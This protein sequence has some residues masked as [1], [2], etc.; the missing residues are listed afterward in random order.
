[1]SRDAALALNKVDT[2]LTNCIISLPSNA[3]RKIGKHAFLMQDGLSA[4]EVWSKAA[5][6]GAAA[7][8][9]Q[10]ELY[11]SRGTAKG[12]KIQLLILTATIRT[13]QDEFD[14]IQVRIDAHLDAQPQSSEAIA[15]IAAAEAGAAAGKALVKTPDLK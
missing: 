5:G 1:M 11:K 4:I 6:G 7:A 2:K 10:K 15:F 3:D 9:E 12:I 8:P 14:A 13:L